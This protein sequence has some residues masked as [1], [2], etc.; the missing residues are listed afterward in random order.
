MKV[1]LYDNGSYIGNKEYLNTV[2]NGG[3]WPTCAVA[4]SPATGASG[5]ANYLA[6]FKINP[7]DITTYTQDQEALFGPGNY[8]CSAQPLIDIFPGYHDTGLTPASNPSIYLQDQA[9]YIQP[10]FNSNCTTGFGTG[11][12]G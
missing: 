12:T 10:T 3:V 7:A 9:P 5:T 6:S 11:F 8:G 1:S 2:A 4:P